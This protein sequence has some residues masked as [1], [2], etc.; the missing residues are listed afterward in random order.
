MEA[1]DEVAVEPGVELFHEGE[2]ADHWW[3][4]VDGRVD[5]VRQAG[6]EEAV[7]M[8]TMDRPGMS[9]GGFHAW[10][11]SSS[12][13]ATARGTIAGRL[14]RVPSTALGEL[15]TRGSRSPSSSW[16]ASSR[17]SA[18][19]TRCSRQRQALITLGELAARLAH[20]INNPNSATVR[21]VDALHDTCDELL[22]SLTHLAERSLSAERSSPSTRCAARTSRPPPR[23]TRSRSPIAKKHS[24][25]RLERGVESSWRIA[26]A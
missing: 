4:L 9:A 7:V 15:A 12:Y 10:D 25:L 5:M 3:V 26:P 22:S 2:H 17:P 8:M 23:S 19:W 13:L 20:E 11:P 16:R 14:L 24:A 18:A 1:G 21:A 6:H